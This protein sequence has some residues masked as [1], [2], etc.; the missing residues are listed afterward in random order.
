M[1]K[2]FNSYEIQCNNVLRRYRS[3]TRNWSISTMPGHDNPNKRDDFIRKTRMDAGVGNRMD[4]Y[5]KG[6]A[7]ATE[8]WTITCNDLYID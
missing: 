4:G 6:L 2:V 8:G 5:D 1:W 7:I 3:R